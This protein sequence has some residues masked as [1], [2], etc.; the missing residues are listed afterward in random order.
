M[1]HV[2]SVAVG[3]LSFIFGPWNPLLAVL[4]CVIALD[5]VTGIMSAAVNGSLNSRRGF[6]GIL[7]KI[8]ILLIV[9]LAALVDRFLPMT[10]Q[11][12]RSTVSM[13]YIANEA[14]SI[15]ENAGEMGI[16]LPKAL[17]NAIERLKEKD[18]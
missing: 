5:Y 12:V 6:Y 13:F 2:L 3:V 17:T 8:F 4:L 15:F 1:Q 11:A 18:S 9:A 7:K 10:N 16:P 14:L